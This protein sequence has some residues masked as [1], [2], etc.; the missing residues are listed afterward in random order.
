M[1]LVGFMKL[2][3][4]KYGI[5]YLMLMFCSGFSFDIDGK[6]KEQSI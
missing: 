5:L 4:L 1:Y 6:K 2:Y 3:I